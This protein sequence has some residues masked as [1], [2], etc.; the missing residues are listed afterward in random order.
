MTVDCTDKG[1]RPG[2]SRL[3]VETRAR[4]LADIR[5]YFQERA[6]MEVETPILGRYANSDPNI[7]NLH[8]D[9][10]RPRFL[11]TSPEYPM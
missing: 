1:W 2:A 9:G 7:A 10:S 3:A 5:S 4:L 8:T 11:R 6:V